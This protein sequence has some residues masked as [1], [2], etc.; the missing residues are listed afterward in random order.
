VFWAIH[1]STRT[2][3]AAA[4]GNEERLPKASFLP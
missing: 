3:P 1:R 2:T 4:F